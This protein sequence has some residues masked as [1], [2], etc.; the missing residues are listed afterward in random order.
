MGEGL[1]D[2]LPAPKHL[3]ESSEPSYSTK[4]GYPVSKTRTEPFRALPEGSPQK[5][6]KSYPPHSWTRR[7]R[8]RLEESIGTEWRGERSGWAQ[9]KRTK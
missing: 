3:P 6:H 2:P 7:E 5:S 8:E 4:D 9:P 1:R